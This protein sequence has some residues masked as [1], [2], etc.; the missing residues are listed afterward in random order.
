MSVLLLL[1]IIRILLAAF[2]FRFQRVT[3]NLSRKHMGIG[4]P[5]YQQLLTHAWMG[6]LGWLSTG[7]L[8]V[9][10]Y[11]LLLVGTGYGLLSIFLFP[12]L[13]FLLLICSLRFPLLNNVSI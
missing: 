1:I 5:K 2:V 4:T 3:L 6:I 11:G 7:W 12:R 8:V 13:A 10:P 9:K